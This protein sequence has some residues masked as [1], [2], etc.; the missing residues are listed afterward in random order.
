[1][2]TLVAELAAHWMEFHCLRPAK[3]LGEAQHMVPG[4]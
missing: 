1:M 3:A 4:Q 2:A